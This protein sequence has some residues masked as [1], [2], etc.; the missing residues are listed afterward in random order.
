MNELYKKYITEKCTN[1]EAIENYLNLIESILKEN[2]K[3]VSKSS[4]NYIYY[5]AHHILPKSLFK[6]FKDNKDNIV[7][8]KPREHFEAHKLLFEAIH[9]KEMGYALW[10]MCCCKRDEKIITPEE[11]E[12]I[13]LEYSKIPGP[14]TGRTFSQDSRN[15]IS[16][17]LKKHYTKNKYIMTKEHHEAS[18]RTRYQNGNYKRTEAQ[19]LST[20]NTLKGRGFVNN[21]LVNKRPKTQEEFNYYISQGWL[22][23]K[24][25]LSKEHKMKLSML[26]KG[27]TAWNKGLPG[28][29]LGKH[30]TEEALQKMKN[31][32][33]T[34]KLKIGRIILL[35][36]IY[37]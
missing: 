13:R 35:L 15:K 36:L 22:K 26:K 14:Y 17:T 6:E 9:C 10:R 7:L 11:Y 34:R 29:F 30:H 37:G 8:L 23:G 28:T 25:P 2:R 24:K 33:A 31:Y 5:E 18:V 19:K 21:G 3:R 4:K 27:C 32:A 1:I 12:S 16:Q 20:S